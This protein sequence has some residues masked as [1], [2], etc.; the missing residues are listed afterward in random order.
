[1]QAA[2]VPKFRPRYPGRV[3]IRHAVETARAVG[4]DVV[5]FDA[6]PDG[7]IRILDSRAIPRRPLDEFERLEAAG[8][9]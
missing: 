3:A 7:T 5:G 9:I 2:N 8:L 1:M 4:L 6:L